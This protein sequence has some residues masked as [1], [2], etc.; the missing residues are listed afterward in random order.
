MRIVFI[1]LALVSFC[2]VVEAEDGYRTEMTAAELPPL[3]EIGHRHEEAQLCGVRCIYTA[4][5]ILGDTRLSYEE[6]LAA[7]PGLGNGMTLR[8]MRSFLEGRGYFCKVE[9]LSDAEMSRKY[10]NEMMF[11]LIERKPMS[12]LV[13]KRVIREGIQEIDP[14]DA[15]KIIKPSEFSVGKQPVLILSSKKFGGT[16]D[17][18]ILFCWAGGI[19]V[20]LLAGWGICRF[21]A[22]ARLKFRKSP[23]VAFF[24]CAL[25]ASFPSLRAEKSGTEFA[26]IVCAEPSHDAG[27][28]KVRGGVEGKV[29]HTFKL[30]NT[31]AKPLKIIRLET[32]CSCASA[33]VSTD[34]VL[35]GENLGVTVRMELTASSFSGRNADVIAV[36]EDEEKRR[37]LYKVTLIAKG[38]Y[39]GY[40]TPGAVDFGIVSPTDATPKVRAVYVCLPSLERNAVFIQ[41]LKSNFPGAI[42]FKVE[43]QRRERRVSNERK[44][45][46]FN[47]AKINV[48]MRRPELEFIGKPVLEISLGNG[49][50]VPVALQA[51]L[52]EPVLFVPSELVF[53]GEELEGGA[54][55]QVMYDAGAGGTPVVASVS[56]NGFTLVGTREVPPYFVYTIAR[57][58]GGDSAGEGA[59][60]VKTGK[61]REMR[62]TIRE[63]GS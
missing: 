24:A 35:P 39:A 26:P 13:L 37:S 54:L 27:T 60:V 42:K 55:K 41:S 8:Q 7:F 25:F 34:V 4:L 62:L 40:V 48:M 49:E 6:L 59:L 23:M 14:P 31:G 33:E 18:G 61:G 29:E 2:K 38:E 63:G 52:R 1:F 43:W 16:F 46:F 32:S 45:Y 56:G 51:V 11:A 21:R 50:R 15:I 36:F 58:A 19:S 20:M 57:K 10:P 44:E 3:S 9:M 53:F 12:H 22:C 17:T 28:V 47:M 5:G 30:K